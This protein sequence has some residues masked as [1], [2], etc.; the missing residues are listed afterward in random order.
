[1]KVYTRE[2]LTNLTGEEVKAMTKKQ[3][4]NVQEQGKAFLIADIERFQ[5][6]VAPTLEV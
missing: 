3:R 6:G 2:E 4:I 5:Q 1:M